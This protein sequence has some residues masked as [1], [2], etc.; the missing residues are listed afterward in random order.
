MPGCQTPWPPRFYNPHIPPWLQEIIL[1]CLETRPSQRY[2]TAKQVG[3]LLTHPD[4]VTPTRRA[5]RSHPPGRW[6]RTRQWFRSLYRAFEEEPALPPQERAASNPHVLVTLDPL[7]ESTAL[8]DSL[9]QAV[10]RIVRTE[11]HSYFTCLSVVSEDELENN[12]DTLLERQV[13]LRR[14][15]KPLGL[16]PERI[17]MQV[18]PGKPVE[19][20]VAYARQDAVDQILLCARGHSASRWRRRISDRLP[21]EAPCTVTVVRARHAPTEKRSPKRGRS[22]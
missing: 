18:V 4:A 11:P 22:N 17:V 19:L 10:A 20:I 13:A 7:R 2:A 6:V 8:L 3:Y 5:H 16:P 1:R 9:R 15:A 14:W 21:L 12:A